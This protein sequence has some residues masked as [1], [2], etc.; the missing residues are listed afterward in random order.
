MKSDKEPWTLKERLDTFADTPH[1]GH[2]IMDGFCAGLSEG[3]RCDRMAK[4]DDESHYYALGWSI[5]E[6]ID[7]IT[8]PCKT[9]TKVALAQI[10]G[11]LVKYAIVGAVSVGTVSIL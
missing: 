9:D 6:I 10:A 3:S 11:R 2:A 8:N 5:G 1:E 7:R 4:Y